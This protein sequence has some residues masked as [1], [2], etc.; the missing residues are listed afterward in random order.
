MKQLP[1]CHV[2]DAGFLLIVK[3][4]LFTKIYHHFKFRRSFSL[5]SNVHAQNI[6]AL[7]FVEKKVLRKF[8]T[9]NMKKLEKL[10]Y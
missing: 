1:F 7:K 8:D 2:R 4:L 3:L 6:G 9:E 10:Q 5:S